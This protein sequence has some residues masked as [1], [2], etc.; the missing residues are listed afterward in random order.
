[1]ALFKEYV[2]IDYSSARLPTHHIPGIRVCIADQRDIRRQAPADSTHQNWSRSGLAEWLTA[3]LRDQVS[4]IVGIDHAFSFP[5]EYFSKYSLKNWDDL[6]RHFVKEYDT[7]KHQV[8]EAIPDIRR[9]GWRK[10]LR[11]TDKWT[12][13]ARSVFDFR[14]NGVAYATFAGLPWSPPRRYWQLWDGIIHSSC[15][16]RGREAQGWTSVHSSSSFPG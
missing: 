3:I 14:P 4:R 10:Q 7:G 6:L 9:D 2:G 16:W 15:P 13:S 8:S 1:M 12:S 11:L 5:H